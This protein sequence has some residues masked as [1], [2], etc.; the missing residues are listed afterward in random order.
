MSS[1]INIRLMHF[2]DLDSV[3]AIEMQSFSEPWSRESF[4]R[5]L[6]VNHA[7]RYVV[8]E[9]EGKIVA[10]GGLWLILDEANITNIAV[11]SSER[12]QGLGVLL[13]EAL[14]RL[15]RCYDCVS[16]TLEVRPSNTAARAL[17]DRFGFQIV[18]VR[19]KYYSQPVEDAL[20][21]R[22][23]GIDKIPY[24]EEECACVFGVVYE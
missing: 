2:E 20:L 5:E 13:T 18:G 11:D 16:V 21:M 24:D 22:K 9:K 19:P 10:Y 1:N 3:H 6:T 23:N 17:Y 12:R 14:L 8:V 15:A 4:E 7:A